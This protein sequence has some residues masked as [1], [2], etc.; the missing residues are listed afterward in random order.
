MTSI[1]DKLN[2]R[3]SAAQT[4]AE[5]E[6]YIPLEKI[7]FDPKQPRKAYHTIDGRIAE[8]DQA[9]IEELAATIKEH[10]LIQ[11]I[12]VE[13]LDDGTYLIRV[14]ECRT[15]AHLF[16]GEKAIRAVVN[17]DLKTRSQRL[18]YQLTENITRN[19]LT[20][21]ETADVIKELMEG[22]DGEA[23]LTQAQV[24]LSLGKSE[25]WVTRYVAFGDE[26][27]QRR[28]V[29]SGV[30]DTAEKVYRLKL[31]PVP[32]QLDI[33]RRVDLAA[34]HVDYLEKPIKRSVI[35]DYAARAKM[36]KQ[37]QREAKAKSAEV[38]V[39]PV[40]TAEQAASAPVQPITGMP[41]ASDAIGQAL[42][43]AASD[44]R[45]SV[46]TASKETAADT[47][48]SSNTGTGYQLPEDVRQQLL[49][50]AAASNAAHEAV[51]KQ[52]QAIR[53]PPIMCRVTVNNLSALLP[54]LRTTPELLKA[55]GDVRCEISVPG[56]LAQSV[57]STLAGRIIDQQ[58]LAATMQ[59][60]LTKLG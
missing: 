10:G 8:K 43:E 50:G 41:A 17:N 19:A 27:L 24:A 58:E 21:F 1:L 22:T 12:V 16:L 48:P 29:Q 28:W 56:D 42:A 33:L 40:A 46:A 57:A 6:I 34:G 49:S 59:N 36:E 38:P 54:L 32:M 31:L 35:D 45:A 5:R 3:A 39:I 30:A 14:G 11:A 55:M 18:L 4:T 25:G 44:G 37:R 13:E 47:P 20:D 2:K 23:P 53:V 52:N 51:A 15:R 26:E 7:R 60:E 9:Y